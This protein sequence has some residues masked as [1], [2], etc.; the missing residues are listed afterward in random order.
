M[1]MEEGKVL[2][3][4]INRPVKGPNLG[5]WGEV[6]EVWDEEGPLHPSTGTKSPALIGLRKLPKIYG[7]T[8]SSQRCGT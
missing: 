5:K 2:R 7:I 1:K 8:A 6:P 3:N 4:T